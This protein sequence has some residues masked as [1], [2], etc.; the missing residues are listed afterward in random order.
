MIGSLLY[1]TASRPDSA[2]VIGVY[3]RYQ[4]N[5]KESH[6]MNVKRIIKYV[7]GTT[8]YCLWYTKDTSSCLV[9]YCDADW[10]GN[11][12]DRKS[13]SGVCFFLGK[14]MVSWFSKK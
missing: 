9:G 13:T 3:A 8:D 7:H 12:E 1:L 10:A 14:N 2:Y 4:E 5:P 11:A 6:L